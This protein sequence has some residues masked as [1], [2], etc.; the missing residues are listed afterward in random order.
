MNFGELN[1]IRLKY[2][3]LVGHNMIDL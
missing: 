3:S 2:M 1:F